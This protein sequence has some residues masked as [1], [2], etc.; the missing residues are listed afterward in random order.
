MQW[1]VKIK[2]SALR[3]LS[4]ITK[5]DRLRIIAAIDDL[6]LNPYRGSA[7]K[8]DLTGLRRIRIGS[9]RVIYEIREAELIV[10]V[11]A[12]GHRRNIYR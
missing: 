6:G 9:Y 2:Q 7:L 3:K 1:S 10:L 12:A 8:G 5:S 4:G 11:V